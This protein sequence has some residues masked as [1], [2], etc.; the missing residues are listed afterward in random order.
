M[1]TFF[2]LIKSVCLYSSLLPSPD[3]NLQLLKL[4]YQN[5][6]QKSP[7]QGVTSNV[8]ALFSQVGM[9]EVTFHLYFPLLYLDQPQD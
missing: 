3:T 5:L 2:Q 8:I 4:L 9:H 6:L 1:F 7:L